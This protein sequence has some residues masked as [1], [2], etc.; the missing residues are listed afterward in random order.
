MRRTL[1][2]CRSLFQ[3]RFSEGLQYRFSALSGA[4]IGIFWGLI[5]CVILT[6]FYQYSQNPQNSNGLSLSAAISYVWLAQV[7]IHL[8]AGSIDADVMEKI[9]SG[10]VGLELCRP[11]DLYFHWFSKNVAIK[12]S[13]LALRG[14]MTLLG[15]LL[16]PTAIRLG[17]PASLWGFLFFLLSLLCAFLLSTAFIMMVTAIRLNITWGDGP[18]HFILLAGNILSGSFLPLRLWPDFMQ[19]FLRFQPFAGYLDIPLQLYVGSLQPSEALF[20]IR[21]QLVWC[22]L[23]ILLGRSIMSQRLKSVIV[24]G[25]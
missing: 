21:I 23:F 1:R 19:G 3:V 13:H 17:P 16:M 7:M 14:S 4:T 15:A 18:M 9:R 2:A 6:V 12:A 5:E 25:G 24:Q 11:L 8:A 22:F 20:H 10:D